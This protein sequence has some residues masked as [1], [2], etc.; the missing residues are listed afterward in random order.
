M[1][2]HRFFSIL[3]LD[4]GAS[5]DEAKKAYREKVKRYHPDQFAENFEKKIDAEEK[6]KTINLAYE[7]VR[8]H[9]KEKQSKRPGKKRPSKEK[10][11][12]KTTKNKTE[13]IKPAEDTIFESLKKSFLHFINEILRIDIKYLREQWLKTFETSSNRAT[14]ANKSGKTFQQVFEEVNSTGSKTK[15]TGKHQTNQMKRNPG[16]NVWASGV[17]KSGQ[18]SRV[19]GISRISP[20]GR[21]KGVRRD[22]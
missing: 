21:I 7:N 8:V 4:A 16:R 13:S 20:I 14:D 11:Y 10:I 17:G 12:S 15:K 1:D 22:E 18:N 3:D 5:L 9:L 19:E 6:L 2:I